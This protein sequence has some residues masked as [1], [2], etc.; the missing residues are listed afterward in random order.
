M[1]AARAKRN[2]RPSGRPGGVDQSRVG[3]L[4]SP[5]HVL[6]PPPGQAR[7]RLSPRHGPCSTRLVSQNPPSPV[8]TRGT[9]GA[10]TRTPSTLRRP[11]PLPITLRVTGRRRQDLILW[12]PVIWERLTARVWTGR[13]GFAS[14]HCSF[15][16]LRPDGAARA[17]SRTRAGRLRVRRPH[18]TATG[19][20]GRKTVLLARPA[21]ERSSRRSPWP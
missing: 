16:W 7:P 21:I 19:V 8:C 9:A 17:D 3:V 13:P 1:I 6:S 14:H 12:T 18:A 10:P 15:N 11:P 2:M 4:G 20:W 5:S